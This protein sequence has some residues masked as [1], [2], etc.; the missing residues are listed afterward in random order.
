MTSITPERLSIFTSWRHNLHQRPETGFN[1]AA[2][3]DYVA[4]VLTDLGI[5]FTRG[6]G[7]TGIVATVKCGD[8][9]EAIGIRA[10]MDG[11]PILEET[12]LDF[13]SQHEGAMHACGHD[14]HMTMALGAAAILKQDCGFNGTVHFVFQPAEEHGLGAKAMLADG[15]LERFPMSSIF[16]LHNS[17]GIPAGHLHTRPG[18]LM[19]SEDNFEIHVHGRGGHASGPHMVIDPIVIGAEIVTAL[20][21][22]VARSIPATES[23]VVSCTEFITDGARNAIPSNVTIKGDTRSFDPEVQAVLEKRMRELSEGICASHGATCDFSY[24]YEFEPT[25]N[26]PSSTAAAVAA[27]IA[28]AGADKVVG[29]C[30]PWMAS[31][32]FGAFGRA[33]PGCFTFIGNGMPGELG[34]IPLHSHDYQFNDGILETGIN[35]YVELVRSL[36]PAK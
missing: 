24:T 32:D 26:D 8:G 21:T 27:A 25:I 6:I 15:M 19:A 18:G 5:E 7:G 3:S 9:P 4:S 12:G 13:A 11:L 10:D 2:T 16:G 20:Q 23:A 33:I 1:E 35:F 14:G 31:E 30:P 17:P 28:A 36:L 34:G 22:V 29:D